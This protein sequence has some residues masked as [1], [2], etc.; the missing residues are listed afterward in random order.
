MMTECVIH[1]WGHLDIDLGGDTW[2][3]CLSNLDLFGCF[4]APHTHAVIIVTD[5]SHS[6]PAGTLIMLQAIM[7]HSISCR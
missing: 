7:G 4:G 5:P 2:T 3:A 6:D 1:A